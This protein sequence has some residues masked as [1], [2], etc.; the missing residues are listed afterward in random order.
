MYRRLDELCE[1]APGKA[2]PEERVF[3]FVQ[4]V[5]WLSSDAEHKKGLRLRYLR[6]Q[7]E[8]Q[9]AWRENVSQTI[10]A[11]L[12][13]WDFEQ[14]LAYG[15]IP[16]D[17][18]FAGAVKEWLRFRVL[19]TACS[20]TDAVE[21]LMLAFER[22][23]TRWFSEPELGKLAAMLVDLDTRLNITRA[24]ERALISL[25]NQLVAQAHSPSVIN[26]SRVERSPFAGLN[27]A[28]ESFVA[29]A[30]SERQPERLLGRIGQCRELLGRSERELT[31]RGADLNTTFQLERMQR[32]LS[33]LQLLVQSSCHAKP[34]QVGRVTGE[35]VNAVARNTSGRLLFERSSQL[36]L[37]NLVDTTA[38]VGQDYLEVERSAFH[39]AFLA[40]AG[41]GVLMSLATIMKYTLARLGLPPIYEGF[42]YSFNYGLAF[43]AAYLLHFTI[44]TK[45]PAHTAAALAKSVQENTGH[46]ARLRKFLG[47]WR[48]L[49]RLQVAGLLGNVLV[50]LPLSFALDRAILALFQVHILSADTAEHVLEN[51]ALLGPSVFYAALTGVF[52][53]FSS[54]AGAA[55]DNWARVVDLRER[56]STHL[57]V[58]QRGAEQRARPRAQWIVDRCG[59]LAGNATLGLLLGGVPALFAVLQLPIDIRH[60]TVSASSYALALSHGVADNALLW[61]AGLGVFAIGCVNVSASFALALQVALSV[62]AG[63]AHSS[64]RALVKLAMRRW[65][66]NARLPKPPSLQPPQPMAADPRQA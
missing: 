45:L 44:A 34:E 11:L 47:V 53:W 28:V 56:L 46:L 4:L 14:L 55:V 38:A 5:R 59:G 42:V 33:R 26:L 41:G 32:Q 12:G 36:W 49:V 19:P 27:G 43:C 48:A 23:D 31:E 37:R 7:L 24:L 60:V 9:P 54:F 16:R 18:H 1:F 64:A 65:L 10:N 62:N 29:Q 50:V 2:T 17:F 39:A 22:E 51:N 25:S 15:G 6:T 40:G 13:S 8:Q 21:V 61:N 66:R 58:M 35:V 63:R 57:R 30:R 20:T 3:W 52:L